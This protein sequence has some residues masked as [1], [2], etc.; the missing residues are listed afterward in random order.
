MRSFEFAQ[1]FS[2]QTYAL[3][4]KSQLQKIAAKAFRCATEEK[5]IS[6]QNCKKKRKENDKKSVIKSKLELPASKR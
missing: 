2:F 3:R 1:N 4:E 6:K 5:E